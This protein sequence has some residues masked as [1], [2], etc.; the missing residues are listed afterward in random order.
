[1]RKPGKFNHKFNIAFF[2]PK[3]D[4]CQACVTFENSSEEEK[5]KLEDKHNSHI[6]EKQLSREEKKTDKERS[7]SLYQVACFDLQATL[8][9]PNGQVSSFYYRSKLSTYNFTV[10][11]L[12]QKGQGSVNC[13]LWHEG[14]GKRGAIE[15]G[16]SLL[17]Y[18]KEKAA[19]CNND[20]LE[21]VFYSDNCTGQQKNKFI[22][23]AYLYAVANYKIK[24]INHKYL[25]TG[26]RP[27]FNR[28]ERQKG[29]KIRSH[30]YAISVCSYN[31][32]LKKTGK[33]YNVIELSHED[34]FDLKHL[35]EQT[36]VNFQKNTDGET[37]KMADA[38]VIRVEKSHLDS[39]FYKTS[40]KCP[41]FKEVKL[42]SGRRSRTPLS[43]FSGFEMKKV[44]SNP[45][46]VA[47]KKYEDLMYLVKTNAIKKCHSYFYT[48]LSSE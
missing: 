37:F 4:H 47:K 8:P 13:Y 40:F 9:T 30:L 48:S 36:T 42:I 2:V 21:I 12:T 16:T 5:K 32:N 34:F 46:P 22:I 23:A 43:T 6:E 7:S 20:N 31:T 3:K 17:H 29:F 38:S 28:K 41:D 25:I 26:Q 10:A 27:F 11:D 39:F 15:I 18:L 14:Q 1:M 19:V 35:T 44:Y 33:P 45:L 24:A